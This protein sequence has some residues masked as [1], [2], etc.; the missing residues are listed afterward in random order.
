MK[1]SVIVPW[2]VLAAL[3]AGAVAWLLSRR[4]T[5][6]LKFRVQ[7]SK[8]RWLSCKSGRHLMFRRESG[9]G[10]C[11]GKGWV[12]TGKT[13]VRRPCARCA[14]PAEADELDRE[15]K[16]FDKELDRLFPEIK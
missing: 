1:L 2:I 12:H 8:G 6:G 16:E 10:S 7:N 9:P 3:L 14:T 15:M 5:E 13:N 11:W 4:R